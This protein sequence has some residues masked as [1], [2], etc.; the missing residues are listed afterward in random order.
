[1]IAY[2]MI[3]AARVTWSNAAVSI[4]PRISMGPIAIVPR[5]GYEVGVE[6]DDAITCLRNAGI[7]P[8]N[9]VIGSVFALLW[10]EDEN[11]S[12]AVETLRNAGFHAAAITTSDVWH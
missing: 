11:I 1:M 9:A 8:C 3:A 4:Q 7:N 2:W 12:Q 10:V 5:F 6:L